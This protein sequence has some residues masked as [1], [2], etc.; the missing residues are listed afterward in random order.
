MKTAVPA[1]IA[2]CEHCGSAIDS[3]DVEFIFATGIVRSGG[4][5]CYLRPLL[6]GIVECLIDAY[7]R[8]VSLLA[9]YESL[10]SSRP[11]DELPNFNILSVMCA[12][13]R[14]AL[15]RAHMPLS[16][17]WVSNGRGDT[18]MMIAGCSNRH[19][20]IRKVA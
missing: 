19:A 16:V 5:E 18:G 8:P 6:L 14:D 17:L 1:D 7:P 20:F 15:A 3:L 10:Y 2:R 12:Q 9:I 4:R 11:P 13:L